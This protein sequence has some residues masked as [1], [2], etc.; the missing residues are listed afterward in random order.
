MT[1][2]PNTVRRARENRA[3][4]PK[5]EEKMW[6]LLRDRRFIK[7]SF[8]GSTRSASTPLISPARQ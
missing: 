1:R 6:A 8:G 5:A 7:P 3:A 2:N 4:M